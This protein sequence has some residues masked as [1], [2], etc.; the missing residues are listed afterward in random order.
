MKSIIILHSA[1]RQIANDFIGAKNIRPVT[2]TI[3]GIK[4]DGV[5]FFTDNTVTMNS[6]RTFLLEELISHK[7]WTGQR[8]LY[9]IQ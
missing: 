6:F 4:R 3:N 8:P 5:E 7:E 1:A 2:E 9:S